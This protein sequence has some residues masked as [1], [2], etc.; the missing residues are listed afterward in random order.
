[1]RKN[2]D[3]E[4]SLPGFH[5]CFPVKKR[6]TRFLRHFNPVS[7]VHVSGSQRLLNNL[8]RSEG[9]NPLSKNGFAI[10]SWAVV[11]GSKGGS[12]VQ[13]T[14]CAVSVAV[15]AA[16]ASAWA[17]ASSVSDVSASAHDAQVPCGL[18]HPLCGM[19]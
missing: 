14:A 16:T 2:K 5:F 6:F 3:G 10:F 15:Q 18:L 4:K 9:A 19:M 11:V 8:C 1:M 7:E 12:M 17:I 13:G